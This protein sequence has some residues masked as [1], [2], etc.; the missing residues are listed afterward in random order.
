MGT[1]GKIELPRSLVAGKFLSQLEAPEL[2][3]ADFTASKAST[4]GVVPGDTSAPGKSYKKTRAWA[5][6]IADAGH[7]GIINVS[8][9]AGPSRCIFMFGKIGHHERGS[10]LKTEKLEDWLQ[11]QMRWVT[12]HDPLHSSSITIV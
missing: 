3:L 5:E 8:R 7:D 10:V 2:K 9:F 1:T 11:A 6:A 12:V 4:F